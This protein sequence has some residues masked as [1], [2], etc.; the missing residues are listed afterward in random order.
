MASLKYF[1]KIKAAQ[2][3]TQKEPSGPLPPFD[4][5]PFITKTRLGE[6]ARRFAFRRVLPAVAALLRALWPIPRL[7]RLVVVTRDA[8][9]RQVLTDSD[10]FVVPFGLEMTELADGTNS[11]LGLEGSKHQRLRQAIAQVIRPDDLANIR[12]W[13]R[14]YSEALIEA[15]GGTIDVV[16]DLITRSATET[17]CR[18]FGLTV[19]D[20]VAFAHW[21]IAVSNLLFADPTGS[22]DTR[23]LALNGAARIQA[24][25]EDAIARVRENDRLHPR[26]RRKRETLVDRLV[27]Q[28]IMSDSEIVA[29]L[30]GLATGFVPTN[31]LAA[32]NMLEE[33]IS[34]PK[35]MEEALRAA[36]D[37]DEAALRSVLFETARLNPALSPGQWRYA[38]KDTVIA[39]GTARGKRVKKGSIVLASIMSALRDPDGKSAQSQDAEEAADLVFGF[40]K[41]SCLGRY[42]AM[43]QIVQVFMVLLAQPNLSVAPG[44]HGWLQRMSVY[45]V[46]LDM[47]FDSMSSTQTMIIVS[48]ALRDGTKR[49]EVELEIDA[50]GNP[51][52]DDVMKKLNATGIVHFASLSV[53]EGVSPADTSGIILLE[54]NVDG[55]RDAALDLIAKRCFSWL[56]P[57]M[58]H[59]RADGS[60]IADPTELANL[61]RAHSLDLH[62]YPWGPIGIHYNGTPEFSVK[63]IERQEKLALFARRALQQYY[64]DHI[65]RR[66]RAMEALTRV[67]R[68]AKQDSFYQ[69]KTSWR[70]LRQD[71]KDF[72]FSLVRPSRKRLAL[73]GWQQ[74]KS[75]LEP[76]RA[77]FRSPDGIKITA[78][79]ILIALAMAAWLSFA[80]DLR[81]LEGWRAHSLAHNGGLVLLAFIGGI[82]ATLLLS[83][84]LAAGFAGVL[85]VH[86]RKDFVDERGPGFEHMKRLTAQEDA[87]GYE[88]NHI[89]AVMPLKPGPFRKLVFA[90]AL[91]GIKQ[92]VRFWFRPGFVV[93]MGTI[94][95]AKWFRV[96]GTQQFVFL[97]NYD[98]NWESYLED[99]ITRAHWG[100]SAAWSNGV[101]FPRTRFLIFNGAKDGDRFKRWVRRQQR[102]SRFWY[103]RFPQLTTKQIRNNAIIEDGLANAVSDTDARRWL[104]CFGSAQREEHEIETSEVQSIAFSGFGNLHHASCIVLLL[105]ISRIGRLTWLKAITGAGFRREELA[106][107][108]RFSAHFQGLGT[109]RLHRSLQVAFGDH[110]VRD[111]AAVLGLS[112]AGLEKLG[113]GPPEGNGGLAEFPAAFNFGMAGRPR[114]LGDAGDASPEKWL[115][116][117]GALAKNLPPADAVLL[118]YGQLEVGTLPNGTA[119]EHRRLVDLQIGLLEQLGGKV[120]HV[121]PTGPL[122]HQDTPTLDVEHFGFRDGISQPVIRGTQRASKAPSTRDVMEPGE[123]LLGYL[124]NQRFYPPLIAVPE[125]SD[126]RNDL[127]IL[128]PGPP[129]RFPTFG[130]GTKGANGR[131]F[132]RNGSFLVVRQLDQDVQGFEDAAKRYAGSIRQRYRAVDTIVG[133]KIDEE[134][135]AAKMVGRWRDGTPLVGNPT[136]PKSG[137]THP[138]NDFAYG[139]DDPRGYQCPF[140]AHIRRANPRDSFEPGDAS[141]QFI[142]NRHR[143]LR[144]GRSYQYEPVKDGV[145]RKG[146]LFMALCADLERQF[147][148]VQHTWI[149]AAS[150]HGLTNEPDPVAGRWSQASPVKRSFT[151][152]TPAGPL[153]IEDV[154]AYVTVRAGG[155]FFLP[156]L[157]ATKYLCS[158][159]AGSSERPDDE[160]MVKLSVEL[161]ESH[162][163]LR[164][165]AG[166]H[167]P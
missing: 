34:R 36:R 73:A 17:C 106:P 99:F 140:S 48:A 132:G 15:S 124:N 115:W 32:G 61:L 60:A 79:L 56:A 46:R 118:A 144:R 155:Y 25:L 154:A 100:Q 53:I 52:R 78:G 59:C 27:H 161:P 108:G 20:P 139:I 103:S 145:E 16:T 91:W 69:L 101:G 57:I 112:S 21:T 130:S 72:E 54:L 98:G 164:V 163:A 8:D 11:V 43:E 1:K 162:N 70:R 40:G 31:T 107:L 67:R 5:T 148:F 77:F 4:I 19:N 55:P 80:F 165:G 23:K 38:M 128:Y 88:Q 75:K 74:P 66:G 33:L 110:P 167:Q 104:G 24:V 6:A 22:P 125:E 158:L 39:E 85:Y 150:F 50:L 62:C 127:P 90:F 41:H 29:T 28:G 7:G 134:W 105:P 166:S 147:E 135:V 123:F 102:V 45:P 116:S 84:L 3:Q 133:H 126:Y 86:E 120:L 119:A 9:V 95:Y 47:T 96:P 143:L 2:E 142:T 92:S 159:A 152:P 30:M 14:G 114:I 111:G 82:S 97:S 122:V 63:D 10:T 157:A 65:G 113:L 117:D 146:L 58:R 136:H 51:A 44:R 64:E 141:E 129:G 26:S 109:K 138:E 137:S 94:H 13:S 93:T 68:F 49:S 35:L 76:L 83:I 71:S 153:V 37:G 87:P 121:V 12:T 42:V 151:I 89:I 131:D 160:W 18:Y 81:W 156:S 149:N